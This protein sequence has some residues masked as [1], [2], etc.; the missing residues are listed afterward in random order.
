M[1]PNQQQIPQYSPS[2][3]PPDAAQSG[4]GAVPQPS[5]SM[6]TSATPPGTPKRNRTPFIIAGVLGGIL[7]ILTAIA[8][9]ASNKPTGNNTQKTSEDTNAASFL[10]PANAIGVEQTSNSISQDVSGLNDDSELPPNKIDDKAL[11]L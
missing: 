3:A 9:V 2:V 5:S 10:I 11:G 1:D 7:L 6:P 8:I 4:Y